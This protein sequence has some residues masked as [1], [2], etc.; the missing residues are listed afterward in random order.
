[1]ELPETATKIGDE[2]DRVLKRLIETQENYIKELE[3]KQKVLNGKIEC[4]EHANS[5][6]LKSSD[7]N[8]AQ[9]SEILIMPKVDL[10]TLQ[11][12]GIDFLNKFQHIIDL[13]NQSLTPESIQNDNNGGHFKADQIVVST[14]SLLTIALQ[15]I[16]GE[17][18]TERVINE[19]KC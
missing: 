10:A 9:T 11:E 2:K 16:L 1:M 7:P 18:K 6:L 3:D 14:K 8:F 4:Y 15:E 5:Q 13:L 19:Q 17:F 12:A